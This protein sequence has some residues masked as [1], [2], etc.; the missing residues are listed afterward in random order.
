MLPINV[1][2]AINFSANGEDR[3]EG[4][5]KF[6]EYFSA[7]TKGEKTVGGISMDEADKKMLDFYKSEVE[8]MSGRKMD[9]Y[10]MEHYCSFT[11]VKEAA[12]TVIGI[13]TDVPVVDALITNV[14]DFAEIKPIGY[15]DTLQIN[16]KPR[17]L[18]V[19]SKGGRAKRSYDIQTQYDGMKTILPEP[20]VISVGISLYDVLTGKYSIGEFAAKAVRSLE[21][22]MAYDIYDAF[23]TALAGLSVSGDNQLRVQGF[24]Q[25]DAIKIAQKVQTWGGVGA[26]PLFLGTKLALSKILPASTNYRF[27]LSSD[28]VRVGHL[29][30]F[31]G[32]NCVELNQIAD[33]TT[34]FKTKIADNRIYIVAQ[35]DR[36]VKAAVGGSVMSNVSNNYANADLSITADLVKYFACGVATTSVGGLIELA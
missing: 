5:K 23:A 35:K 33:Y 4:Y 3:I 32:F 27:D 28:Y 17:D 2:N 25:D 14:G 13:M 30:D 20:Y 6:A 26:S 16:M 34:E 22:S 36:I 12:F 11:D 29:R 7:F 9:G 10:K 18:L 19:V 1:I 15:G 8:N 21:V 24:T 31:F